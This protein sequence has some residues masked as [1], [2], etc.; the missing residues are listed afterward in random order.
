VPG[1]T[2]ALGAGP[3]GAALENEE[4]LEFTV[5][6]RVGAFLDAKRSQAEAR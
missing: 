2:D 6:D 3:L 1:L 4:R 5:D